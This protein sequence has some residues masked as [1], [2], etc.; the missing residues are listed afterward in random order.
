MDT[1]RQSL[2][3]VQWLEHSG[4]VNWDGEA[5]EENEPDGVVHEIFEKKIKEIML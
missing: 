2:V 5:V 1:D 4:V 3:Q